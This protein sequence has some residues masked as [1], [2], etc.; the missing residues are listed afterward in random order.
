[1]KLVYYNFNY[2]FLLPAA[3]PTRPTQTVQSSVKALASAAHIIVPSAGR[4]AGV[5]DDGAVV[6]KRTGFATFRTGYS[7]Y[8]MAI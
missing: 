7:D 4:P 2:I 6:K 1:M 5:Y 8:K 3:A